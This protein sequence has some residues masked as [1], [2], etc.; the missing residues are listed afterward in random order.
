[1]R[2]DTS[3]SRTPPL[4]IG[5]SVQS[6]GGVQ[7]RVWAP[8]AERVA[9]NLLDEAGIR[10]QSVA[11]ERAGDGY[12]QGFAPTAKAGLR[13][14]YALPDGEFP[15]PA[16]RFQPDGPHGPSQIIDP[17]TFAWTDQD[18]PGVRPAGQVL[19]E[20]HI[21]TF[22]RE[23]TWDSA[24]DALEHLAKLGISLIEVM[25]VSD[26]PGSHGWGYDGVNLF[27][28]SRLYGTPDDFRAFVDRAHGLNLG[29]ILDVVYN[30][31]GP[32]G[33]YLRPFSRHYVSVRYQNEWGE[34]IN[35][36][37]EHSGP[38]REFFLD[39]AA[40]WISEFHLDGLRLDATQQIFDASA[41][42][43]L[44]E[45]ARR[46]RAAAGSRSVYLVAENETQD[47]ALVR[48]E[49]EGGHGLDAVW[50][51]DFHHCAIVALTGKN[52]AYFTDYRGTP[53]EFVS[54][55][56]WGF[57]YQGQHY[58]WQDKR[59]GTP[60]LDLPP[61]RFI[62]FIQNHDQI[63]NS[64]YG[65]RIHMLTSEGRVRA[66]TAGLLLGPGTPM[67][68]QGQE[69]AASTPFLYFADHRPDIAALVAQGRSEFLRQFPSISSSPEIAKLIP[70]PELR[71]TFLS[72]KLLAEEREQ[73]ALALV[74]HQDLIQLR[75][76]TPQVTQAARGTF[77]GAVLGPAAF[78]IRYFGPN[79][80][81]RL[82]IVNLGLSLHL[83]VAPEPLLAPVNGMP[84]KVL[85][86]SEDPR[87][88]GAGMP[89]LESAENWRIPAEA[90]VFLMPN[91]PA[92]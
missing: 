85:W 58:V 70:N 59:R 31:F 36:D 91:Q 81:D 30:H 35:F 22:T 87:Y 37:G 84:W 42:S 69:F 77:D 38:V 4:S 11:L 53:Q 49:G 24:A 89:P 34:A 41:T 32:D 25:P 14:R 60:S 63:A 78:L 56:K 92:A 47:A 88:G 44:T 55:A 64:L 39:N 45:I 48:T 20:L 54:L 80:D 9:V 13:Y 86:S 7:F 72:C 2:H 65:R 5:A 68:F 10:P 6:T 40:Y 19:Y 83:D 51:D 75:K 8:S 50:N 43:I 17:G 26:F 57:L 79:H 67:L 27:A 29:V 28:P 90:A 82:L 23:G 66:M 74:L 16:S 73:N 71:E 62:T 61:S 1:M 18:W 21:G 76:S 15:D 3:K 12:F 52:E 46:A 33:N